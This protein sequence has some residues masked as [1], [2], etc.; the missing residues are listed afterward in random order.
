MLNDIMIKEKVEDYLKN[1]DAMSMLELIEV[2]SS[3]I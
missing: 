2:I 1:H 3:F